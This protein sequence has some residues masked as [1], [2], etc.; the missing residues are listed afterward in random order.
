MTR[1][2]EDLSSEYERLVETCDAGSSYLLD[3]LEAD[4]SELED[5]RK[6]LD[7]MVEL[8]ESASEAAVSLTA[9]IH[10]VR[11]LRKIAKSL[12]PSSRTIERSIGRYVASADVFGRW[13]ERI[14]AVPGWQTSGERDA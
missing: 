5:A 2:V 11:L 4:P 8:A 10:E 3:Q 12:Q 9:F 6:G 14:E 1:A 7:S 13:K